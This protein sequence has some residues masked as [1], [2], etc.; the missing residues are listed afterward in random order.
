[1]CIAHLFPE[2]FVIYLLL[3]IPQSLSDLTHVPPFIHSAE[4]FIPKRSTRSK[5]AEWYALIPGAKTEEA[6][7]IIMYNETK[8]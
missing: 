8:P 1:M 3:F 6:F 5:C 4:P 7:F 2:E